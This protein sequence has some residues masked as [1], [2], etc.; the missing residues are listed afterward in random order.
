MGCLERGK[1]VI[2]LC[3][4]A[5]LFPAWHAAFAEDRS[6]NDHSAG[7]KNI[8]EWD[9]DVHSANEFASKAGFMLLPMPSLSI[10]MRN[11]FLVIQGIYDESWR[12]RITDMSLE[13][14]TKTGRPTPF[15]RLSLQGDHAASASLSAFLTAMAWRFGDPGIE[16]DG[17]CADF[18]DRLFGNVDAETTERAEKALSERVAFAHHWRE[19]ARLLR[20]IAEREI[21]FDER[22]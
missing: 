4:L 7:P 12:E 20:D 18:C 22:R 10:E 16:V 2:Q 9:I 17:A 11:E 14:M 5:L 1:R 3:F 8:P 21:P 15:Y 13:W 6:A 19:T